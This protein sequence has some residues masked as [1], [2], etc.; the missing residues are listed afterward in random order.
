MKQAVGI[1]ILLVLYIRYTR[2][3]VR[4]SSYGDGDN[5]GTFSFYWSNGISNNIYSFRLAL[6]V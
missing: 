2:S 3:R 5:A 1:Q 6:V 4:G